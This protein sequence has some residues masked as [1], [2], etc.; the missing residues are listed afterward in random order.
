MYFNGC[1]VQTALDAA[2]KGQMEAEIAETEPGAEPEPIA[3]QPA[4]AF[5]AYVKPKLNAA[6]NKSSNPTHRR[7]DAP[8]DLGQLPILPTTLAPKSPASKIFVYHIQP[9]IC[10]CSKS[11]S[12]NFWG[13]VQPCI[14]PSHTVDTKM[15]F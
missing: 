6:R 2:E 14:F 4:A 8:A 9:C 1:A 3:P 13:H 5:M 7:G 12:D 15:V 11:S 10:S